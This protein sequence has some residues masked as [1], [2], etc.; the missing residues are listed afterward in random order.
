MVLNMNFISSCFCVKK[1]NSLIFIFATILAILWSFCYISIFSK[2]IFML[3]VIIFVILCCLFMKYIFQDIDDK[4]IC[5][6]MSFL[7]VEI[8]MIGFMVWIINNLDNPYH[9]T[10]D[11]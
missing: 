3:A 6:I 1:M 7:F 10:N 5:F 4:T 11:M 9:K 8:H 2:L